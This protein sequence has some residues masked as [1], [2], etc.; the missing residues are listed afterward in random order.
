MEWVDSDN[1]LSVI[2]KKG[3]SQ[4]G[5]NKKTKHSKFSEKRTFL[6]PK[7]AHVGVRIRG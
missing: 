1:N 4:D 6:T 5:G 3:E 7:C 2:R